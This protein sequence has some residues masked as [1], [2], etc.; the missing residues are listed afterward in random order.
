MQPPKGLLRWVFRAPVALYRLR[1]GW[2]LGERFLLLNHTGRKSGL[3]RQTVVE[4]VGHD[5][6]SDTYYIASGFGYK[7]DWYR[8]LLARPE[9]IIQVGWRKLAVRAETLPPDAGVQ[10]LVAYRQAHPLAAH[11]LGRNLLGIDIS[12]NTPEELAQ[13]VRASLPIIALRPR[14]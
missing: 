14:S 9:L 6:V 3:A 5:K 12:K 2:L 13:F 8:N 10:I 4:V 11:E 7:A 1:L